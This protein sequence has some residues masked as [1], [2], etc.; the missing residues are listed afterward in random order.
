MNE[1]IAELEKRIEEIE[2][3]NRRVERNKAWETSWL[4]RALIAIFTYLPIAIYM[5]YIGV[6]DPWLNAIVPTLGFLISTLSLPFIRDMIEKNN[7][8]D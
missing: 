4:R 5:N 1:K 7:S 6:R 2:N 3:R 8:G